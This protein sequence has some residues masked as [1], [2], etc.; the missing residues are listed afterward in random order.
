[1]LCN[2][3]EI[4]EGVLTFHPREGI[5]PSDHYVVEFEI[6]QKFQRAKRVTGQVYDFNFKNGNFDDLRE[7]ITRVPFDI[8]FSDDINEHWSNWK[9]LFLTT[10]KEHIPVKSVHDTNSPPWIDGEVRHLIS[11]KYTALKKFR[12][13]KTPER[14]QK[15][16]AL[17]QKIKYVTRF[18]HRQYLQRIEKSF[19]DNPKR[20]WSYHKVFLGGRS[21][22]SPV[23]LYK[24]VTAKEPA[25][26]VEFFNKYFCSVFLPAAS[27]VNRAQINIPPKTDMKISQI[28]VSVEEVRDY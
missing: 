16:R 8:A 10:V 20:F 25:Q 27:N 26:K 7:S 28:E 13:D 23:I 24:S 1:M 17:S 19:K 9:D 4:I 3:P 14:K 21:S 15:L 5:F 22:A 2:W 12:Q 11:K 18:K 6:R